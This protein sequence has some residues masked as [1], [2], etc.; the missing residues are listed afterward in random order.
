MVSIRLITVLSA[1]AALVSAAPLADRD[2]A[3]NTTE[4]VDRDLR[5]GELL[6][7][8]EGRCKYNPSQAWSHVSFL[9]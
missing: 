3:A 9:T 6:L 1:A 7:F 2:A 5:R 8:G 4:A